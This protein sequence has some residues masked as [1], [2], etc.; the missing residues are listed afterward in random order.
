MPCSA[1]FAHTGMTLVEVVVALGISS[2]AIAGIISGYLYCVNAA[3]KS[4]YSLAANA[5]AVQCLE[6]TRS[7]KWDLSIW[8]PVD[9]LDITNFPDQVV[10][11]DH[12]G[13]GNGSTPA[14][15]SIRILQISTNP[16]LKQIHVD[17]VW[18]FRGL[19]LMTNSIETSRAPDQ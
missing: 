3:E 15:N 17:C 4:A 5:Q 1:G 16:P 14:T 18:S 9:Q 7:A 2:V 19:H 12:A 10:Q 8:P 11:L 13:I 6:Q